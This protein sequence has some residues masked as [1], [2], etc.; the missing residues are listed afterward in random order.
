MREADRHIPLGDDLRA[1]RAGAWDGRR[2]FFQRAAAAFLA[3]S[4]RLEGLRDF[5][6]ALPPLRPPL[7]PIALITCLM[8][9]SG[10]PLPCPM[11][12]AKMSAAS[13]F[14]SLLE[15]FGISPSYAAGSA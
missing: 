14:T 7:R 8:A 1:V 12:W 5:A 6:L 2:Y 13:W 10:E 15:R 11:A 9:S 3:I 4:A